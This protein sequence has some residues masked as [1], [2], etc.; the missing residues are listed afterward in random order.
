MEQLPQF[1]LTK[2][3]ICPNNPL[4]VLLACWGFDGWPYDSWYYRFGSYVDQLNQSKSG[5]TYVLLGSLRPK[6]SFIKRVLISCTDKRKLFLVFGQTS[7]YKPYEVR[8]EYV[9]EVLGGQGL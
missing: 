6:G 1:H 2:Y 8:G 5:R 3:I 7:H 4:F 9:L